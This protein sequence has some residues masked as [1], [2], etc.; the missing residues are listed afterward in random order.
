MQ[1]FMLYLKGGIFFTFNVA[2]I[3]LSLHKENTE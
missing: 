3:R 1:L 2:D